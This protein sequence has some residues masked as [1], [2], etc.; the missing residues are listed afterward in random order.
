MSNPHSENDHKI[1][2]KIITDQQFEL[3][4][5]LAN[6]KRLE[7]LTYINKNIFLTKSELLSEFNLQRAGLDFHLSALE[8]AGLIGSI[9]IKINNR[10]HVFIYPKAVWKIIIAPLETENLNIALPKEISD[11]S[12]KMLMESIW[13]NSSI[14]T[15][16][17]IKKILLSLISKLETDLS[18]FRCNLCRSNLG[19]LRCSNCKHYI[20][21]NCS[22]I[23]DKRGGE[24]II[25]CDRC[26]ADQFS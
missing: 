3:I 11:K 5:A 10:K 17:T 1:N 23:I 26:I 15:P 7:I 9:D 18:F 22:D 20:C 16:S 25:L 19:I 21:Q 8:D 24:R 12:I 6:T 2:S 4:R 14:K 13:T